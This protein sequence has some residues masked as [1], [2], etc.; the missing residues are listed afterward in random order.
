MCKEAA[1][2]PLRKVFDVLEGGGG[3]FSSLR[4][5]VALLLPLFC[6]IVCLSLCLNADNIDFT[7]AH[8]QPRL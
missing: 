2:R 8:F 7:W 6:I 1:M 4:C 3:T 5:Y